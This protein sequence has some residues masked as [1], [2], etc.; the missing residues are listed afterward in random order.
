MTSKRGLPSLRAE[1]LV[2]SCPLTRPSGAPSP[3]GEGS[4]LLVVR[5]SGSPS[6]PSSRLRRAISL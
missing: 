2:A 4:A 3:Q 1:M 5:G 6:Y